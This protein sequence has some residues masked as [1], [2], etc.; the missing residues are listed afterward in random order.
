[1]FCA[2][3]RSLSTVSAG[4]LYCEMSQSVSLSLRGDVDDVFLAGLAC[5]PRAR[6][7]NLRPHP[8]PSRPFRV[9]KD[10][11]RQVARE[12]HADLVGGEQEPVF[13]FF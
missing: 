13:L 5:S 4:C 7:C 12:P 10:V 2:R 8:L 6:R 11:A 9:R 1:M 3:T